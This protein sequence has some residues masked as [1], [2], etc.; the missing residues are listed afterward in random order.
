MHVCNFEAW[1]GEDTKYLPRS[2][3]RETSEKVN[4]NCSL[5][6]AS[7]FLSSYDPTHLTRLAKLS[8]KQSNYNRSRGAKSDK[9]LQRNKVK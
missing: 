5:F 1:K 9:T 3:I 8:L 4:R 6:S 7:Y 2:A